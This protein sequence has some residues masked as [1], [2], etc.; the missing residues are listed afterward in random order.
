M[1][2]RAVLEEL[3]L[4][5][6]SLHSSGRMPLLDTQVW[7]EGGRVLYEHYRKPVANPL[8][9]LE[10]SAMP[11]KMKRTALAQE[12]VRIRRNMHPGLPWEST[13]VH[14]DD[15]SQRMRAS[16]YNEDYRLQ[17]IKSG[18]EGFDRMMEASKNGGRPVNRARTWEQDRRQKKKELQKNNWYRQGGYD[19]PLFVPHTPGGEL[20]KRM[21]AKE[22]E[23]N[24]GRTIRFKIIEKG[25]VT[26]E[27]KL[28]RSNPWAGGKCGRAMCF[29][30][31]GPKGGNC[32][33]EGVTYS[34]WCEECG[35]KVAA[36][37]GETGRNGFTRGREHLESL[38]AKNEDKSV[39][40]LH[41]IFHHQR[42]EDVP[43]SMRVTG[44]Y[45]DS[46]DR[47]VME[48]VHISNWRGPVRMNRKNEMG[49]VRVERTE[50]RRWGG[51]N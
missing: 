10:I 5:C 30:C 33:R 29:P 7:V 17:V 37:Q 2:R 24:Q 21:R 32:W 50:Y 3:N 44:G 18:V 1:V 39:L 15:F 47:Q 23:N 48:R 31:Q 36:Y 34:L 9:M 41:S 19:V 16:G 14:L 6:P 43:Y 45:K 49:G 22:G 51:D 28:R 25:G 40:W 26:L 4:C 13:V 35:E 8:L 38:E 11:A 12:V 42:R 20:A 46:L 27:K